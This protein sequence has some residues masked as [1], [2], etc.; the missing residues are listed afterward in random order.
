MFELMVKDENV[1]STK[2]VIAAVFQGQSF[3]GLEY[4]DRKADGTMCSVLV[5]EYPLKDASDQVVIGICAE[6][7]I[8]DR[9]QAEEGLRESEERYRDLFENA[10]DLIQSVAPDG[11]LVYVNRAWRETLGYSEEEI[12]GLSLFDVIH[13][14]SQGHCIEVFNT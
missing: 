8:T 13:P 14:D 4:E 11:S 7:D 12:P 6:L 5:S 3:Y 2:E 10:N 1:A 9:K